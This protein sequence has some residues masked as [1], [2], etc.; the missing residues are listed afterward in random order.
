MKMD[1]AIL[2]VIE[3]D[4]LLLRALNRADADA[5]L[6]L[7]SDEQVNRYLDRPP[8]TTIAQA[9]A[10][11]DK[12]VNAH[13]MYWV[14]SL[15]NAPDLIGTMCLWNFDT[16]KNMAEVGY[17]LMPGYQGKGIMNEAILAVI[18]YS[19]NKLQLRVLAA[20][21]HPDNEA[22]AKL[23]KRNGFE[24]DHANKFISEKDAEGQSVYVL[25]RN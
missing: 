21:M 19:F 23:L 7:R 22:S 1:P 17:E 8:T 6:K 4:R 14:I 16:E 24:P 2:P 18:S 10:F 5:L 25:I 20:I 12:I 3:T 13:S 15:K 9:Q 11:I